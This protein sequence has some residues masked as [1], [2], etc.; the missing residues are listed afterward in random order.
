VRFFGAPGQGSRAPQ[1]GRAPAW[2]GS[3]LALAPGHSRP[4]QAAWGTLVQG[5]QPRPRPAAPGV[6]LVLSALRQK[7]W[8]AR[9]ETHGNRAFWERT[10]GNARW[11]R[12]HRAFQS[13]PSRPYPRQ[14]G[15]GAAG[16]G[17]VELPRE[18]LAGRAPL[19]SA[20]WR[21]GIV[22]VLVQVVRDLHIFTKYIFTSR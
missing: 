6:L 8:N 19:A 17:G 18:M 22:V 2:S 4:G 3:S 21:F 13:E 9:Y 14:T 7:I 5:T 10:A 20:A 1:P 12:C 15:P 11:S 16:R